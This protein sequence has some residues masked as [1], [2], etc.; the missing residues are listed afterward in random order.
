MNR[1]ESS[2]D[3]THQKEPCPFGAIQHDWFQCL[4]MMPIR[5]IQIIVPDRS[6]TTFFSGQVRSLFISRQELVEGSLFPGMYY[7]P[8][9]SRPRSV[10]EDDAERD[11][12]GPVSGQ[13]PSRSS[14]R[15]ART[16]VQRHS[17]VHW[18][19][20]ASCRFND[21][22]GFIIQLDGISPYF[23]AKSILNLRNSN[24]MS[25]R[26]SRNGGMCMGTVFRR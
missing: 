1:Q 13:Q 6:K 4:Q 7:C 18:T 23:S 9:G 5:H 26:R 20:P 22:F 12:E 15:S 2:R 8:V 19:F 16:T 25:S 24:R 21:Q 14:A 11:G 10:P 3:H 17:S